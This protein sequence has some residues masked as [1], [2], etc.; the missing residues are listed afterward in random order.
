MRLKYHSYAEAEAIFRAGGNDHSLNTPVSMIPV[1]SNSNMIRPKGPTMSRVMTNEAIKDKTRNKAII[2]NY[3]NR[4][5]IDQFLRCQLMKCPKYLLAHF[6][7][8]Q[9]D[10]WPLRDENKGQKHQYARDACEK[11]HLLVISV[12]S[13]PENTV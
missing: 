6:I 2:Q 3:Q 13:C 7:R 11:K 5:M 9:L 4:I 1:S 8:N 12:K 10:Y